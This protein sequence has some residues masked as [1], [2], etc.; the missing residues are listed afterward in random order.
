[1]NLAGKK[2]PVKDENDTIVGYRTIQKVIVCQNVAAVVLLFKEDDS[3]IFVSYTDAFKIE[4]GIDCP[5]KNF[6]HV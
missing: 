6:D 5:D 1:M 4:R 2:Y 3:G